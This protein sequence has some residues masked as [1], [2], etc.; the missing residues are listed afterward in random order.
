MNA[1]RASHAVLVLLVLV[2][3]RIERVPLLALISA[4]ASLPALGLAVEPWSLLGADSV[5]LLQG[6][7]LLLFLKLLCA[8]EDRRTFR[9]STVPL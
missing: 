2:V 7:L 5:A 8:E 3:A 9:N 1:K 4:A 6:R